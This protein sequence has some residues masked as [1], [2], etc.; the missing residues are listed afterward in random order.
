MF[1]PNRITSDA[2]ACWILIMK[3]IFFLLFSLRLTVFCLLSLAALTV[4]GTFY[5]VGHGLYAAQER[6]FRAWIVLIA[7]VIPF[8]GVKLV[9]AAL[10]CNLLFAATQ[11]SAYSWKTFGIV[12]IHLGVVILLA[13]AGFS[14]YFSREA[15]LTLREGQESRRAVVYRDEMA[16]GS[17]ELPVQ[18]RLVS[19]TKKDYPGTRTARSFESRVHVSGSDIDRDALIAMNKPFRYRTI[20]IYQSAYWMDS[21]TA[22]S[23][24]A[25]VKNSGKYLPYIATLVM[26][27]GLMIHFLGKLAVFIRLNKKEEA[28]HVA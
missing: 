9:V 15:E 2:D 23:T 7:G 4:W 27:L 6:F 12:L 19:F 18:I 14:N 3:N 10:G 5:Q 22:V 21:T 25:V 11:R 20:T 1:L 28:R 17:M 13:G 26:A 8:P 24:F 16:V